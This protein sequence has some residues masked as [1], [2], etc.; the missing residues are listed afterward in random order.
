MEEAGSVSG[1]VTTDSEDDE[2]RFVTFEEV[3]KCA[4][5]DGLHPKFRAKYVDLMIGQS[6]L[7]ICIYLWD[8]LIN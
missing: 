8:M 7:Y 3:F 5:N 1:P 2:L 4:S 6:Q